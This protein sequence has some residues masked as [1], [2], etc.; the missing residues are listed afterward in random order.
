MRI[1]LAN[2]VVLLTVAGGLS[3]AQAAE[4]DQAVYVTL[5][6]GVVWDV[7]KPERRMN[8]AKKGNHA[9]DVTIELTRVGGQW[10]SECWVHHPVKVGQ[11]TK[12]TAAVKQAA[13]QEVVTVSSVLPAISSRPGGIVTSGQGT[14]QITLAK[15]DKGW[16]GTFTGD[17][18][19]TFDWSQELELTKAFDLDSYS[20]SLHSKSLRKQLMA[21]VAN[22]PVKGAVTVATHPRPKTVA[23]PIDLQASN[24]PHLFFTKSDLP[25]L[26]KKMQ[27]PLGQRYLAAM[28]KLQDDAD[29]NGFGFHMP[30]ADHSMHSS[31][32]SALGMMYQ[33]TG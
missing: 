23:T 31:W 17:T 4:S 5:Q 1:L 29:E 28:K 3:H 24:H 15:S 14:W 7:V 6:D 19:S 16:Q 33:L 8:W 30:K 13:G 9:T 20:R 11:W 32:A 21:H 22:A 26:K 27:T 18:K 2:L 10:A 25:A 12:A